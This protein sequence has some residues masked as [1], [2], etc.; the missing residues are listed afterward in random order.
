LSVEIYFSV[1]TDVDKFS[2][3]FPVRGRRV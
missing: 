3:N 2:L 1:S